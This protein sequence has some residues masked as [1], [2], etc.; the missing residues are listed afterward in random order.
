IRPMTLP[1]RKLSA[2]KKQCRTCAVWWS[3]FPPCTGALWHSSCATWR[4]WRSMRARTACRPA[5]SPS[6]LDPHCFAP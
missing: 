1:L 4:G 6:C 2:A 3:S 5:T